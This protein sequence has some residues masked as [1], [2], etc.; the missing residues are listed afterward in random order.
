MQLKLNTT[1]KEMSKQKHFLPATF[2]VGHQIRCKS[3]VFLFSYKGP[4]HPQLSRFFSKGAT[5]QLLIN[6]LKRWQWGRPGG[7]DG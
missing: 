5:D 7:S 6:L 4:G 2:Q 3:F 1:K